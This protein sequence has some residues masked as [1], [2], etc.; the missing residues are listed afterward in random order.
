M[1]TPF[2][3]DQTLM[4]SETGHQMRTKTFD[5]LR[6]MDLMMQLLQ[7]DLELRESQTDAEVATINKYWN[8]SVQ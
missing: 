8:A 7:S 3:D 2:S 4:H 6:Q 5:E 1:N